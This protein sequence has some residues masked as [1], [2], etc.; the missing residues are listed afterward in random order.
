M[1]TLGPSTRQNKKK[2]G[3]R[4]SI[5]QLR[6]LIATEQRRARE[7]KDKCKQFVLLTSVSRERYHT[8]LA[9]INMK[10][11][12]LRASLSRQ[13]RRYR[14]ID[15]FN[16]MFTEYSGEGIKFWM[17]KH[18]SVEKSIICKYLL[19]SEVTS[20]DITEYLKTPPT[21]TPAEQRRRFNKSFKTKPANFAAWKKFK[22]YMDAN[23]L[24]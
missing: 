6:N 23:K 24:T 3:R 1:I 16:A 21:R 22:S 4:K 11:S 5:D 13:Y 15:S 9:G 10:L 18:R 7:L 20:R 19:E 14:I 2:K 17:G 8:I 12:I